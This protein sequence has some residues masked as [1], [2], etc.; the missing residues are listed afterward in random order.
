MEL[1]ISIL[2]EIGIKYI[3]E[4]FPDIH[5]D[6]LNSA[7]KIIKDFLENKKNFHESRTLIQNLVGNFN[8]IDKLNYIQSLTINSFIPPINSFYLQNNDKLKYRNKSKAWTTEEDS[9]L[10]A[11]ILKF[12][13]GSWK[14]ISSFI[15]NDR[16]K[17]QCSQRWNRGIDPKISKCKWTNEEELKLFELVQ[18][19]GS[20]SWA[21]ISKELGTRCD[22]QCRYHFSQKK[23]SKKINFKKNDLK[24][25]KPLIDN[26]FK[27]DDNDLKLINDLEMNF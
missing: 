20:N 23:G 15:G 21:K 7:K 11:G 18:K 2:L 6:I 22:V 4:E 5:L 14:E 10:I 9:R 1:K 3:L 12:G 27:I 25:E 26:V 13:I 8:S 16:T 17:S 24:N 19:Y